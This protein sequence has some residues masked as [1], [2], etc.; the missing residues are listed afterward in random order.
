MVGNPRRH[1]RRG[2]QR[3]MNPAEVVVGEM[4]CV[5]PPLRESIRQSGYSSHGHSNGQLLALNVRCTHQ[6]L[7][8]VPKN[9]F[10][11][12]LHNIWWGIPP[13]PFL[14]GGKDRHQLGEVHP[15]FKREGDGIQVGPQAIRGKGWNRLG[16]VARRKCSMNVFVWTSVRLRFSPFGTFTSIPTM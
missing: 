8:R 4:N 3:R 6:F 2:L 5:L 15:V 10:W 14:R 7:I 11:D 16:A 1:C 12:R 9:D 13:L